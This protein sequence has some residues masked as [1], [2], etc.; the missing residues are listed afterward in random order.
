MSTPPEI[1]LCPGC[2]EALDISQLGFF[3]RLQCPNCGR[4]ARVHTLLANFRID[5]VLGRGGMSVVFS[6]QDLVLGRELAIKVLND[7]YRDQ[8][9][10]IA[11]FENECM[12]MAK[13]R[14]ENVV[15]VYSASWARGQFYIAME[16]VEG[17]NLELIVDEHKCLLPDEALDVIH[18]VAMGL[19]AAH[20]AGVLHRDM[21]PGN[22]I[23]TPE[24]QVKVL[25]FGLSQDD[26]GDSEQEEIIWATPF[27]V[28]PETL[29]REP[30]DARTD[31]YALGMT[32]RCLIT[33]VYNLA[34]KQHSIEELL[35]IKRK[36]PPL[37]ETYPNIDEALCDLVDH[38]T[39]FNPADR[40]AS[41]DELLDEI[42]EVRRSSGK[43]DLNKRKRRI[44]RWC[45]GVIGVLLLGGGGAVGVSY[46]TPKAPLYR[47]VSVASSPE[48]PER[49][50]MQEACRLMAE[51]NYPAAGDALVRLSSEARDPAVAIGADALQ[52]LMNFARNKAARSKLK[53]SEV[54]DAGMVSPA[55]EGLYQAFSKVRELLQTGAVTAEKW[56][57]ELA[58]LSPPL[59]A[60]IY[61]LASESH[62]MADRL[63][64][65]SG[66]LARAAE[67]LGQIVLTAPLEPD[68][69]KMRHQL[70]RTVAYAKRSHARKLMAE[71]KPREAVRMLMNVDKKHFSAAEQADHDVQREYCAIAAEAYDMLKRHF[72][73]KFTESASPEEIRSLAAGLNKGKLADELYV[74]C[75]F[76]EGEYAKAFENNPYKNKPK[77]KEPFAVLMKDWKAR[78]GL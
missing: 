74:L 63:P 7:N 65:A 73:D 56:P 17:R 68:I 47:S 14:H 20:A 39:A 70:P 51:K 75:L 57:E 31:I 46:L 16:K 42:A 60:T 9:E 67:S 53:A 66:C 19:R 11:R 43:V 78:L 64:E 62:L 22:I 72:P 25:D 28:P 6:A 59:R 61:L 29:R 15:S 36:M 13:V 12:L 45:L 77:S 26:C 18:Q 23:I 3:A 32:L 8:P 2:G 40:P 24:G 10:R 54:N 49:D 33:G 35:D 34:Q 48:W 30:E 21:K 27:Y 44:R 37:I 5:S 50:M 69:S 4:K 76:L 71:G 55:A 1:W 52:M 41:Y 38:M 58:V